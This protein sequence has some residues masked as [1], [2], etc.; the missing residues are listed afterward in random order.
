MGSTAENR[1]RDTG[2]CAPSVE[3]AERHDGLIMII[4]RL[5]RDAKAAPTAAPDS[6]PLLILAARGAVNQIAFVNNVLGLFGFAERQPDLANLMRRKLIELCQAIPV[7][8]T[9][10]TEKGPSS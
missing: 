10:A 4:D 5:E 8:P 6:S 1:D 9:N 7:S 2:P 3:F